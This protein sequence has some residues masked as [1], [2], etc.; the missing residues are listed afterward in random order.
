LFRSPRRRRGRWTTSL[1]VPR[2]PDPSNEASA[3]LCDQY[4]KWYCG[5]ALFSTLGLSRL[6]GITAS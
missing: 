3:A 1:S 5:L 6:A 4:V 2:Y